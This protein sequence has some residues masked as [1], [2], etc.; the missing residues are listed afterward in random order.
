MTRV[1]SHGF[2]RAA[3]PISI[4]NYITV[5]AAYWAFTLTD[6]ALRMLVLLHFNERGY[7]PVQLAFLFLL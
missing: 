5:T 1:G 6:G 7:T 3:P 4:G 2:A